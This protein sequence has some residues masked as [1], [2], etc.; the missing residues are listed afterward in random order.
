M[1]S[2]D[3][4]KTL[5]KFRSWSVAHHRKLLT[6]GQLWVPVASDLNDPFDCCIPFRYDLMRYDD[7]LE[8]LS[9][10]PPVE[11]E[12]MSLTEIREWAMPKIEGLGIFDTD[13][14]GGVL[15]RLAISYREIY[16]ILSFATV[17][18][19]LLLWSHYA[20]RHKG[21]C[22]GFDYDGIDAAMGEFFDKTDVPV[23][24]RWI[25]YV[26]E[27]PAIIPSAD[28]RDDRDAYI[29]LLTVKANRWRYEKEYR[30]L[31]SQKFDF[32]IAFDA[33]CVSE[34]ILGSEMSV[35][36]RTAVRV[37]AEKRFPA[38]RLLQARKKPFAFELEFI[39]LE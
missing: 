25:E 24:G 32:P 36:D 16:G 7:F 2:N 19:D 29:R 34:V 15:T 10:N 11:C 6:E 9:R 20:D 3:K 37:F 30:Y 35:E 18:D 33:S 21:F 22:V 27:Q 23:L 12:G 13:R 38:A 26:K 4:P 39:P 1:H 17:C 5:Y 14:K 28:D 31:F 8:R